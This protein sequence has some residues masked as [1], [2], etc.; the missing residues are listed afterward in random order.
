[1]DYQSCGFWHFHFLHGI[2]FWL[3]SLQLAHPFI[4][5]CCFERIH[6]LLS[7]MAAGKG[8]QVRFMVYSSQQ[9]NTAL[10]PT[11]ICAVSSAVA[12]SGLFRRGSAFGR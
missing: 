12:G 2:I 1:L 11:A 6:R 4:F 8:R 9:P 3:D 10:E 5:T 7:D